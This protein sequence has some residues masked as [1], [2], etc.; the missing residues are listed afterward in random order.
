MIKAVIFDLDNTLLDFMKMKEYA[1]KAAIA[2][3]IEAGLNIDPEKSYETIIGIYEEEGWENQQV[4]NDFLNK[5]IGEVNNKYLAAGI[6]AYRRARE[7][8]LLLYPN[9]NH[10]LVELIK[11]GVKLAVVSDAPSREAWMRIYYLNLHHHF[12]VVLT[13]DDTNVRKPSPIPFE[14]ALSQL[15]IDAEEALM[16]GDWPERDVVGAKKLGIRTIF[17]RYGDAFGTVD[18]GADWDINDVYEIVG[19]VNELNSG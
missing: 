11:R 12:D 2:G 15:N 1:V 13:F 6:V 16:V 19:I 17:A 4:F 8:N 18:S 14:M 9:V 10:T 5:T 7:A 3:M